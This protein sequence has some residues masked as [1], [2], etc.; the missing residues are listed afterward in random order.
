MQ[1]KL[2]SAVEETTD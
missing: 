1:D 2:V